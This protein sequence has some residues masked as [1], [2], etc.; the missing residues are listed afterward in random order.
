MKNRNNS[1]KPSISPVSCILM[2]VLTIS[3]II[4]VSLTASFRLQAREC[5]AG[6]Q[7][8]ASS[9]VEGGK[10][11]LNDKIDNLTNQIEAMQDTIKHLRRS[12]TAEKDG[13]QGAELVGGTERSGNLYLHG[14]PV[15][16]DGWDLPAARVACRMLGFYG[17]EEK[18]TNSHFGV[19]ED[20]FLVD[21]V[22][23]SGEETSLW[24][25][26]FDSKNIQCDQ[27]EGA[28]VICR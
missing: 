8:L 10:S 13:W 21:D 24:Y 25:C 17:A 4:S 7:V 23:C 15:C 26:G 28:G 11:A 6:R 22:K 2:I 20:N 3:L 18:T 5:L 9:G 1:S 16:D 19:V 27:F 12:V 14:R